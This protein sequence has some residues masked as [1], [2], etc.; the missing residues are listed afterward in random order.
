MAMRSA[1]DMLHIKHLR[2]FVAVARHASLARACEELCRAQTAVSRSVQ[3]L[4]TFFGV[5]LFERH[6][7]RWLL[8]D[9]GRALFRRGEA[10]FVEM[11]EACEI[12]CARYPS[13]AMRLR[14]APYFALAV[15]ERRI[16]LLLTFTRRQH[17][18]V[19]A[20]SVGISQPAASIALHDLEA[21]VGVPLFDRAPS[22]VA[23]TDAG[24]LLVVHSKR[25][26]A[27]LRL[28]TSEIAALRGVIEGQVL[29]GALPYARSQLL[30]LAIAKLLAH[31]PRLQV[32]TIEAPLDELMQA[33]RLGDLDFLVGALHSEAR[34]HDLV[35]EELCAQ[36]LA[37]HARMGHPLARKR[38]LRLA[39]L[40]DV[41]WVLPRPGS[42]TRE[43]MA[44]CLAEAGCPEPRVAVESSDLSVIRGLLLETDMVTASSRELFAHELTVGTLTTLPVPLPG[45][46]RTIGLIRRTEE[47]SSPGAKLLV[48]QIRQVSRR[49]EGAKAAGSRA[50][51]VPLD[52]ASKR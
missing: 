33:V 43:S 42:P 51:A 29:V 36:P 50:S 2:P 38:G 23:L 45:T 9:F 40:G 46:D 11:Q 25:A 19:A 8:T 20:A 3:E 13:A 16:A 52:A 37:I 15:H 26:L 32:R 17:I 10:A 49:A 48:E 24:E 28:A 34:D 27:Q 12:L 5:D 18:S 4:E 44:E 14:A 22:G 47:N 39:D 30:P 31:H 7:R 6:T 1:P 35:R 41:T 21:S